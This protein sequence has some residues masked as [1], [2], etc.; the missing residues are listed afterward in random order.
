MNSLSLQTPYTK[1][2]AA[3]T[4][5]VLVVLAYDAFLRAD[6]A[7]KYKPKPGQP[8]EGQ[9][10][11]VDYPYHGGMLSPHACAPQCGDGI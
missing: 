2:L 11:A 7:D 8:C 6:P 9:A 1:A 4:L 5:A 10:L 3:V